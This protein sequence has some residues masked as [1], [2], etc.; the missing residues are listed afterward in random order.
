M[1]EDA[2]GA[3]LLAM[4][5]EVGYC[6]RPGEVDLRLIGSRQKLER[7]SELVMQRLSS[8][9]F[10]Q[11]LRSLRGRLCGRHVGEER[12]SYDAGGDSVFHV[13]PLPTASSI[14]C[15]N[16][17]PPNA[18]RFRCFQQRSSGWGVK[19]RSGGGN[20]PPP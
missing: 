12:E 5:L 19:F 15:A 14:V 11:D 20:F 1:V 3:D 13:G 17:E 9:I 7:A 4:G 16:S 2:V 6:A 8:S 10:T 18:R